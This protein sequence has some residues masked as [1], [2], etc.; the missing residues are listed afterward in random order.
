VEGGTP[1]IQLQEATKSFAGVTALDAVDLDLAGGEI[2][3][4]VG[5]NGAGKSTLV[6]IL[7][8]VHPPDRGTLRVAG[9]ETTL[10]SPKDARELGLA[11]IYQQ[12][13]LFP[14]LDVAENVFMGR[15]PT[16]RARRVLWGEV[17]AEVQSVLDGLGVSLSARAPVKGLSVADQQ[18]VEITRALSFEAR[19]LIMDEPTAALSSQEVEQLFGIVRRLRGEGV[20]VMFVSHRLEE[21][22][23]LADRVSVLR[24]GR[25]VMTAPVGEVSTEGVIKAMVGRE[26]EALFPKEP[27]EIAETVLEVTGLSRWGAFEDVGFELHRGEILG[28][29][30][31][32]GAGRTEVARALFGVDLPDAGEIRLEGEPVEARSPA[33]AMQHGIAYVPED[34]HEHGLVLEFTVETNESLAIL[35]RLTRFGLL[36]RRREKDVA[37]EY[38]DRLD[39]RATG[40]DQ[41]A[42]TLSGGNQQKVVLAK[43]LATGPR[44]LILDEPTQGIDIGTK[45]EVHRIVSHLA[46]DGMAIILISSDLPEILAMAD[47]I[48]VMREG[49]VTGT[50]DR[51]EADQ[52]TVMRAATG[53][54][55]DA[56]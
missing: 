14:D 1:I 12:P 54:V 20:A 49:R 27:A 52:E 55:Q 7:A 45:A 47:R 36:D 9:E 41:L 25:K 18:L 56:A 2:H 30:G 50:F 23:E 53:Q 32:V 24:D 35:R 51:A 43:W 44:V 15:H 16:G 6:K 37:T 4:L 42:A 3:A 13:A 46:A 8:G 19:V 34:R 21:V 26:L 10:R 31:L 28:F 38:S 11:V 22:F 17:Y 29:A 33:A 39:V 48:V 40:L 5:E